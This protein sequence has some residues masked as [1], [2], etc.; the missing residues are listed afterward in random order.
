ML[1]R[2]FEIYY[3]L[4]LKYDISCLLLLKYAYKLCVLRVELGDFASRDDIRSLDYAYRVLYASK[5]P[6]LFG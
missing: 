4:I 3:R 6:Y 1:T 5:E 2:Y